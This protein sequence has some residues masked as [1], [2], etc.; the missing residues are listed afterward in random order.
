MVFLLQICVLWP[1]VLSIWILDR[2]SVIPA[3]NRCFGWQSFVF[4]YLNT[5]SVLEL[6]NVSVLDTYS[7]LTASDQRWTL[8]VKCEWLVWC[9]IVSYFLESFIWKIPIL[10]LRREFLDW[11]ILAQVSELLKVITAG[12]RLE[13]TSKHL[14]NIGY[15]WRRKSNINS[16]ISFLSF[17][18]N[19]DKRI[20]FM[21]LSLSFKDLQSVNFCTNI[22][23]CFDD[24]V[25]I[26]FKYTFFFLITNIN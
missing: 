3:R 1:R 13:K 5:F 22:L 18:D 19:I 14:G 7:L 21:V 11:K 12:N 4:P 20:D 17:N 8:Q 15:V 6:S 23:S 2:W 16:V 10:A 24:R 9:F 25:I 26:H